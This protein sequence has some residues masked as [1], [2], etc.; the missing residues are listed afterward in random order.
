MEKTKVWQ[1]VDIMTVV[2]CSCFIFSACS[3][4]GISFSSSEFKIDKI[5]GDIVCEFRIGKDAQFSEKKVFTDT[6]FD[7]DEFIRLFNLRE[8]YTGNHLKYNLDECTLKIDPRVER[9]E[10][11][12]I[13]KSEINISIQGENVD[14]KK[15]SVSVYEYNS[16]MYFFVLCMGSKSKDDQIGYYFME[17]PEDMQE[18][19]CPIFQ[20]VRED[21]KANKEKKLGSFVLERTYSHDK[22]YYAECRINNDGAVIIEVYER[23]HHVISSFSPCGKEDFWGISWEYDNY[24]LWVQTDDSG[25]ICY[26]CNDEKWERNN[27][28]VKPGYLIERR[29]P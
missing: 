21:D 14:E 15:N 13:D 3:Y 29:K 22:N 26:S 18:Y 25:I 24:N 28:A 11:E 23:Y 4:E 5:E 17:L 8:S 16:K 27:E 19:W 1:I 12:K 7:K 20:K 2:L 9:Q 10:L 6:V